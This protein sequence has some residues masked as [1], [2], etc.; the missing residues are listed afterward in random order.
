LRNGWKYITPRT[1]LTG[2]SPEIPD[3]EVPSSRVLFEL[4]AAEAP[5]VGK[6]SE[7]PGVISFVFRR[8]EVSTPTSEIFQ[9]E[10]SLR[11][12]PEFPRIG[13]REDEGKELSPGGQVSRRVRQDAS[14]VEQAIRA[15]ELGM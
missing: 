14:E 7:E 8:G 3:P 11:D 13:N 10:T 2:S 1:G 6:M 4:R 9:A 15:P 5:A 12:R